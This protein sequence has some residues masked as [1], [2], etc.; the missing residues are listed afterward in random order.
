M[1]EKINKIL[2]IAKENKKVIENYF[3]MTILQVLNSFFYLLVYPYL[4]RVLGVESYG[5]FVFAN[6]IAAYFLFFVNFGLEL[7][8]VKTVSVNVDNNIA[9]SN[10]LSHIFTAKLFLFVISSIVFLILLFSVPIFINNKLLFTILFV[11]NIS[12]ILFPQWFFQGIQKMRVVTYIQILSK[13]ITLPFVFFFVK[14]KEDLL[15][16]VAIMSLGNVLAGIIAFFIV[17]SKGLKITIKPLS[18]SFIY[19][20]EA[21]PFFYTYLAGTIKEYSI[22][23]FIGFFLTMRDVAIYD[24]AL[25]V[26]IIPRML[27]MS[28]NAAIFPKLVR[29][30]NASIIKKII[31]V[32]Y[33]V[34]SILIILLILFGNLLINILGGN[35]FEMCFPLVL[36]LSTTIMSWLVVTAY[37]NFVFIPTNN[38]YYVTLNQIVSLFTCLIFCLLIFVYK[39]VLIFG[40]AI[41]FSAISEILFCRFIVRK[42]SMLK[43]I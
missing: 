8:S 25:K 34:S 9:L 41:S 19:L 40:I 4:I 17:L 38:N 29:N 33:I 35:G 24:L 36:F 32:E 37:I 21:L 27:I 7:P 22:P 11:T 42:N 28:I 43:S 16:Y 5:I 15:I 39:N 12:A 6:S 10:I 31:K 2:R 18:E 20:K 23:L 1:K 14:S 13:F 3:F 26:V 30:V